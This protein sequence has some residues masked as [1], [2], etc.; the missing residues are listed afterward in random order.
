MAVVP[1]AVAQNKFYLSVNAAPSQ[2]AGKGCDKN[3][4]SVSYQNDNLHEAAGAYAT[5]AGYKKTFIIAPNYPAGKDSL[6]GLKRCY[7]G[8]L[9]DEVYTQLGQ[10][11]YAAEIAPNSKRPVRT[12][13]SSSCQAVWLSAS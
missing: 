7:K 5:E 13:C 6:A 10:T 12:V 9:A 8:E 2:L 1:S 11:D 3:Y 4:F